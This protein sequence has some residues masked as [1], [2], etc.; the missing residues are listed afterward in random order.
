MLVK[1]QTTSLAKIKVVGVGGGGGNVVNRMVD[2]GV[3]G[4]QYL[5]ANT[6]VIEPEVRRKRL[7]HGKAP[8]L[9]GRHA[10]SI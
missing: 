9:S 4:V 1:P 7:I 5:A 10:G 6:D 8:F 3:K 2:D